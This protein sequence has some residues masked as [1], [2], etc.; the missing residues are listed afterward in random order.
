MDT[1]GTGLQRPECVLATADGHVFCSG[2]DRGVVRIR[3]DGSQTPLASPAASADGTPVLANGIALRDDGS[4]LVANIADGGGLW[5]LDADGLRPFHDCAPAGSPPP[6]VNFVTID[7]AGTVWITVSS[8]WA[9]RSRAYRPD[10]ANGYVATLRHGRFE[11]VADGFA[12]TNECLP[13]LEGGWLYVAETMGRRVSRI[14]L[15][16][17]GLHG[18]REGFAVMPRGAF[19]DGLAMDAE[20][21]LIC[22]CIVAGEILRFAPDGSMETWLSARH[23][24]GMAEW[25]DTVETAFHAGAMD[26]PHLD[27]SPAVTVRNPSSVCFAGAG[28]D[29]LVV[30]NI[31]T[32]RLPVLAAPV[33]GRS[34]RHWHVHVPE[35][36]TRPAR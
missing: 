1:I 18:P 26:R 4:F 29:R 7:A 14:R 5:E 15:D 10:V 11:V 20:G 31:L 3:P 28:L 2:G 34:P 32:D 36:G 25:I 19:V 33:P 17:R 21:G 35:G 6:P 22:V 12:Y 16:E 8:T 23:D 27:T 24:P 30:G 13:D 9:P